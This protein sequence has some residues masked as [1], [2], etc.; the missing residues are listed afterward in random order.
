MDRKSIPESDLATTY[1]GETG[2]TVLDVICALCDVLDG[3]Q[4]HDLPPATGLSL[5]RCHQISETRYEVQPI[6]LKQL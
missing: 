5:E 1:I 2:V 6:W 3:E 4:E